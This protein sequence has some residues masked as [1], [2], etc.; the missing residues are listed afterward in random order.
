L[1]NVN[2][3]DVPAKQF[4]GRNENILSEI[5]DIKKKVLNFYYLLF[6]KRNVGYGYAKWENNKIYREKN[7]IILY[8][9]A[10]YTQKINQHDLGELNIFE[11]PLLL[12]HYK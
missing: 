8:R 7:K 12:Y 1:I 5:E 10:N 11:D 6:E 2:I 4:I 3:N 9:D